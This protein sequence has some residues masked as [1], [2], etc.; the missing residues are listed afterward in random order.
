MIIQELFCGFS[1]YILACKGTE[2]EE[3]SEGWMG[4]RELGFKRIL[5]CLSRDYIGQRLK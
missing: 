1:V 2:I 3:Y 5:C 4:S